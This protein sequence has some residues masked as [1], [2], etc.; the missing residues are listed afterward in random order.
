[1][2]SRD[3]AIIITLLLTNTV[4]MAQVKSQ[5]VETIRTV[6]VAAVENDAD[7]EHAFIGENINPNS[8]FLARHRRNSGSTPFGDNMIFA[9][10]FYDAV[11]RRVFART[12]IL[13]EV[14]DPVDIKLGRAAG[15]YPNDVNWEAV[16]QPHTIVGRYGFETWLGNGKGFGPY[17]AAVQGNV[18]DQRTGMLYIASATG[19]SGTT[20]NGR[21]YKPDQLVEHVAFYPEGTVDVGFNTD[22][23]Q[24]PRYSLVVRGDVRIEGRVYAQECIEAADRQ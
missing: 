6:P 24:R 10:M 3:R 15:D 5:R 12:L 13:R 16:L 22:P 17:F 2:L 8:A 7:R 1:M 14:E 20:R 18:L 21:L 4:W 23:A 19:K 11:D 9:D